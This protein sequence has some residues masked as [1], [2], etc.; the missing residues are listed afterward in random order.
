VSIDMRH[1][2]TAVD[3]ARERLTLMGWREHMEQV[4]GGLGFKSWRVVAAQIETAITF[5]AV[6][7]GLE[8]HEVDR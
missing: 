6:E 4:D 1:L 2:H 8:R 3:V 7:L 5:R